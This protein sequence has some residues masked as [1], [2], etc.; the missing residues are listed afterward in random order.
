M[1]KILL[2]LIGLSIIL[3]SCGKDEDGPNDVIITGEFSV[4]NVTQIT[5]SGN[6]DFHPC[7]SNDGSKVAFCRYFPTEDKVEMWIWEKDTGELYA[8]VE[9][10]R[11]DVMPSWSPD[12]SKIAFDIRDERDISQI[13]IYD[14]ADQSVTNFSNNSGN[15]FNPAW[16]PDGESI[17]FA[18]Q[19]N[20]ILKNINDSSTEVI[21]N[22]QESSFP[23]WSSDGNRIL[24]SRGY[25]NIDVYY[26]NSDGSG[27]TAV[28]NTSAT[29]W[30]ASWLN[31]NR[32]VVYELTD[33][34]VS[35]L[36]IKNLDSGE[37]QFLT[38][39]QNNRFPAC[40]PD[41]NFIIFTRGEDLWLL[42][43]EKNNSES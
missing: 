24:F 12:D 17:A 25:P 37:I 11:G 10:K 36:V 1:N 31:E 29:E 19:N 41:G 30:F 21:P 26:V 14:F 15:C 39:T 35:E 16:S 8:V 20:L 43:I 38:T 27:F 13:Y 42:E 28:A 32:Y 6:Y 9:N 18:Y 5:N 33:N 7:W 4:V 23:K 22:T 2:I 34:E 40:S 3:S